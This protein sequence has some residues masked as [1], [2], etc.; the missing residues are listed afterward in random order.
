ML[1][2]AGELGLALDAG[3][4]GLAGEPPPLG[5]RVLEDDAQGAGQLE[6]GSL[7]ARPTGACP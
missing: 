7:A 4:H 2:D 1:V 3:K 5:L 6:D